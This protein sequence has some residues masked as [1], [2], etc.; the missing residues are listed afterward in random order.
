MRMRKA[1]WIVMG[2][3]LSASL[4]VMAQGV[5]NMINYQGRLFDGTG[6]PVDDP[7]LA[8]DF[9]LWD[10]DVTPE[11]V[12]DETVYLWGESVVPL[13]HGEVTDASEVVSGWGS[14]VYETPRDYLIDYANGTISRVAS[15]T[16]PNG[17]MVYVD[18][19]WT[20]Y[21]TEIWS[22]TQLVEV[23][24]G[25]YEVKLGDFVPLGYSTFTGSTVYLE[26]TANL[27][28]L[29]P[30]RRLTSVVFAMRAD[31]AMS[32][33]GHSYSAF[34]L[35][36]HGHDFADISGQA[37]DAQVPDDITIVYAQDSGQ[38]GGQA[39]AAYVSA[40]GDTVTGALEVGQDL[41]VQG[42]AAVLGGNIGLGRSWDSDYG[43]VNGFSAAPPH[44]ARLYGTNHGIMGAWAGA[45]YNNYAFLG[46]EAYGVYGMCGTSS[47]TG[48]RYGGLFQATSPIYAIGSMAYSNGY[49]SYPS[50]GVYGSGYNASSGEAYGGYFE[51]SNSGTGTHYGVFAGVQ[52]DYAGW[53]Q[54]GRVHIGNAGTENY[55]NGDGDLYVED[56]LEVD[57]N[58]RV[59][60]DVFAGGDISVGGAGDIGGNLSVTGGATIGDN[61]YVVGGA[62]VGQNLSAGGDVYIEG[63]IGMG[64]APSSSYGIRNN[65]GSAPSTGAY[66]YGTGSGV[67]G[68]WASD[69]NDHLGYMGASNLGVYGRAGNSDETGERYGGRFE[70][71]SQGYAYGVSGTGYAFDAGYS[72]GLVG[73]A[74]ATASGATG[75]AYGAYLR[76]YANGSAYGLYVASG[77]KNWVNP[78]PEDPTKSIVYATLEGGENGTYWR[79]TA[80]LE[81]G[82]AEVI[83]PDHFRKTTSPDYPVT[84]TLGLLGDCN[85]IMVAEK[86]NEKIVVK[87]LRGGTSDAEFDF[88]VMGKRLGYEEYEP[89]IDNVDYVPFQGNNSGMDESD[90]T[91]QEYYDNYSEGLKKIFKKNGIL[92]EEGKVNEK[93]FEEKGWKNNKVKMPKE[94]ER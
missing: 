78:D 30:R 69:P 29:S 16:I 63:T 5:P 7:A 47:D 84:V 46:S 85:G 31:D 15:G 6:R 33:G 59:A 34:S 55:V 56:D 70:A 57:N 12:T 87:E 27:E 43:I 54:G 28:I 49:G 94:Q 82:M 83:L 75:P 36:G 91:T 8:M 1:R 13:A 41:T 89:I 62:T 71:H 40:S 32:L 4:V 68:R 35:V 45:P 19:E 60:N 76:A 44:G 88:V 52:D 10:Q 20:D 50:I 14:T 25:L 72:Y 53:F 48:S 22:E 37:A 92:D 3:I 86:S 51:T 17:Q 9:S 90:M 81:N 23:V 66:L 21:G 64:I 26:V 58:A 79:G 93:L 73:I 61:L 65:A 74:Y 18:Y 42:D 24:N 80:R 67:Q 39:P 38:L 11:Q 2:L 77:T